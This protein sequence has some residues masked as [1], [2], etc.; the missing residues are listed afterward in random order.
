MW[1]FFTSMF[2]FSLLMWLS[3]PMP[4]ECHIWITLDS[5]RIYHF[6]HLFRW[7]QFIITLAPTTHEVDIYPF[8][9]LSSHNLTPNLTTRLNWNFLP[10]SAWRLLSTSKLLHK[11]RVLEVFCLIDRNDT[12]MPDAWY[13][14]TRKVWS[15]TVHWTH[16]G[17]FS[18]LITDVLWRTV[19]PEGFSA[20]SL[21]RPP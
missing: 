12:V 16:N 14:I 6:V 8:G 5:E 10:L 18:N 17:F 1:K 19:R 9:V 4:L 7:A 11:N 13:L 20:L 21:R 15:L 3:C 2:R